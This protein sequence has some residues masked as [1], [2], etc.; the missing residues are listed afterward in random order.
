MFVSATAEA[1]V[2]REKSG[3]RSIARVEI[4][5][6]RTLE[7]TRRMRN[8]LIGTGAGIGVGAAVGVAVCPHCP[9]EGHGYKYVGP[10]IAVGAGI[11]A[12]LG[13]LPKPYRTVYK[14]R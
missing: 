7:P 5:R 4:S 12:A 9:N 1:L 2:V 10:G 13:F 14:N 3:E 8:G 6:L 11:G